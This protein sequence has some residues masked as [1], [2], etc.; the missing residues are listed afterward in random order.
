[1]EEILSL[2][3]WVLLSFGILFVSFLGA[4]I[5]YK[6][7]SSK[8]LLPLVQD[9]K[10]E[11]APL[12][13][14]KDETLP[15]LFKE[16]KI[17]ESFESERSFER[18]QQKSNYSPK[19]NQII[20][21][22]SRVPDA[23]EIVFERDIGKGKFGK[24]WRGTWVRSNQTIRVALRELG[25]KYALTGTEAWLHLK[26]HRNIVQFFGILD[27]NGPMYLVSE[28][29]A[30]GSLWDL[31]LLGPPLSEIQSVRMIQVIT[32]GLEYLHSHQVIHG[33]LSVKNILLKHSNLGWEPKITDYGLSVC[34]NH[35]EDIEHLKIMAPEWFA[36]KTYTFENDVW[37]LGILMIQM[38]LCG[39]IY[40]D[41]KKQ[42]IIEGI[43]SG[44]LNLEKFI[45]GDSNI[46][47]YL[48]PI[49]SNCLIVDPKNRLL[50]TAILSQLNSL[51]LKH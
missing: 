42:E 38:F 16:R 1:M 8:L 35:V 30:S 14:R 4:W 45:S 34:W 25:P 6:K 43:P 21:E 37:S 29:V 11:K 36:S 22:H 17:L 2:L 5:I 40:S 26:S 50:A 48:R 47:F 3:G 23:K 49:I 46:P 19:N 20:E 9:L 31:L 13:S 32:Q 28:F 41:K 44:K 7:N 24:V 27:I 18:E 33:D 12:G 39:E 10:F 51:N 15:C